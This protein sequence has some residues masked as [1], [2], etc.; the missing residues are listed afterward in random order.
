M[1]LPV[2]RSQVYTSAQATIDYLRRHHPAINQIYLIG[3]R[4]LKSEFI[5][6]GF[7]VIDNDHL[8]EPEAVIVGFDTTLTFSKLC[9]AGY[10]IKTGK[11]FIA[12]HPDLICPTD[13]ETLLVDCGS[14]CAALEAATGRKPNAVLGKPDPAMIRDIMR[15]HGLKKHEVAMVGDRLC[16]DMEMARQTGIMSILVLSGDTIRADL[17]KSSFIPDFVLENVGELSA[18]LMIDQE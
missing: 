14:I 18:M 5:V 10:W 9:R 4:S 2:N 6:N 11:L 17:R 7:T 15:R 8:V 16:T 13:Q 3:T 12:T 1:G